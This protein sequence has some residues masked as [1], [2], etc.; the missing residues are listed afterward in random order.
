MVITWNGAWWLGFR[1]LISHAATSIAR[2]K[3]SRDHKGVPWRGRVRC[4]RQGN[5]LLP[6]GK[7]KTA[8]LKSKGCGTLRDLRAT[9]SASKARRNLCATRHH[10]IQHPKL[11]RVR[12]SWSSDFRWAGHLV[13]DRCSYEVRNN[14]KSGHRTASFI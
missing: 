3:N 4:A 8:P 7:S 2:E 6:K 11:A 9:I 5:G 14:H 12:L 1:L 13:R 10:P